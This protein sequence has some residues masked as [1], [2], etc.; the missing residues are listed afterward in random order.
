MVKL[1]F[2]KMHPDVLAPKQGTSGSAG[3]DLHLYE[4]K[5]GIDLLPNHPKIVNTGIQL[6][7]PS[8]YEVQIRS[9]SGLASDGIIVANSPGTIDSDYLGEIKVILYNIGVYQKH[10]KHGTRIAQMVLNKLPKVELE[11]TIS[12]VLSTLSERGNNG[13]GSTGK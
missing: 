12:T 9:R 4:P 10:V 13:F 2:K 11:E 8:G 3:F 5:G 6:L 7:I 1:V